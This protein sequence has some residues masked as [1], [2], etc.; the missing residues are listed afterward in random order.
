MHDE[1]ASGEFASYPRGG[2]KKRSQDQDHVIGPFFMYN[3]CGGIVTAIR[4]NPGAASDT[5]RRGA[6]RRRITSCRLRAAG[7]WHATATASRRRGSPVPQTAPYCPHIALTSS[8]HRPVHRPVHSSCRAALA[9]SPTPPNTGH[10]LWPAL[11]VPSFCVSL[12]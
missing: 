8:S 2:G 9:S 3:T 12:L 6:A 4:V 10:R 1:E 7:G 5:A 11:A